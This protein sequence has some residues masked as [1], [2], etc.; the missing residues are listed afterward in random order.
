LLRHT[1]TAAATMDITPAPALAARALRVASDW[2]VATADVEGNIAPRVLQRVHGRVPQGL[3]GSLYRNG[4]AKFRRPGGSSQHW[5]DGDGLI[6]RFRIEEGQATLAARFA[7]TAKRRQE[8]ALDAMV[9]PGFG[10]APDP[11]A[12]IGSADDVSPANTSVHKVGDKLW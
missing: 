7:D 2:P 5:F 12:R 1:P 11:R 3:A 9:M 4:P 10:T 8:A 6:R